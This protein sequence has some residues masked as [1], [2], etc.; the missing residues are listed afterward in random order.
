MEKDKIPFTTKFEHPEEF[1]QLQPIVTALYF[2]KFLFKHGM[3][4]W[5]SSREDL[6]FIQ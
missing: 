1:D 5:N 3:P 4:L 2:C 6:F